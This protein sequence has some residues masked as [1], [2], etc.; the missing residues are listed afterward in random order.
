MRIVGSVVGCVL[1]VLIHVMW[2]VC[3]FLPSAHLQIQFQYD[4]AS[5]NE[6]SRRMETVGGFLGL[7]TPSFPVTLLV[8]VK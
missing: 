8:I 5:L 2:F 6:K 4:A 1:L 3:L 7:L